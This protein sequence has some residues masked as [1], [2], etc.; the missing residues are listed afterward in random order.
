MTQPSTVASGERDADPATDRAAGSRRWWPGVAIAAGYLLVAVLLLHRQWADP[1]RHA[2]G[3]NPG[4]QALQEWYLAHGAHLLT[5]GHGGLFFTHLF[6]APDGVNLAANPSLILPALLLTPVTLLFGAPVAYLVLL[7]LALAGTATGWYLFLSRRFCRTRTA[8]ALG[9]GLCGFAPGMV[10]QTSG[11]ANLSTQILV[12]FLVW[13]V[14]R[15]ATDGRPVRDGVLLGLAIT[16]QALTGTEILLLTA[17]TLGIF[18]LAYAALA[19]RRARE[20]APRLLRGLG[21]AAAVSVPL[22][23]WPLREQFLGPMHFHGL[24]FDRT[25]YALRP[26]S[27]FQVPVQ[28][29][30]GA[31]KLSID[32]APGFAE[33]NAFYGTPLIMALCV[34]A[35]WLRRNAVVLAASVAAVV[36]ALL[37]LGP[38]IIL[39]DLDTGGVPGPWALFTHVPILNQSLPVRMALAVI[40]A[41]AVVLAAG[42]DRLGDLGR[43]RLLGVAGLVVALVPIV[44]TPLGRTVRPPVP[45]FITSGHWRQCTRPGHTLVPVPLPTPGDPDT[46]RWATAAGLGF[47]IPEG[48]F[49]GP[50]GRKGG[51]SA[52]LGTDRLT[53]P[54]GKL[55]DD[56]VVTGKPAA[57]GPAQRA[58]AAADLRY[59]RADCV[60]LARSAVHA[61]ALRTTLT[62]LLG[63][64]RPVDDVVIWDR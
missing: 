7:T 6:N 37:S 20:A 32:L 3:Y 39:K 42:A 49:L 64:G 58:R 13:L 45:H 22:L 61:G 53:R 55:L 9:G 29:P 10:A 46:M 31:E 14:V 11:H 62:R 28:S 51:D 12:P 18:S 38:R 50:T 23:A 40:P 4:D 15:L 43:Y 26:D 35:W 41:F 24:P 34:I 54:T 63:P 30:W 27:Y 48:F 25:Y 16:A 57:V 36:M 56:V 52:G 44:P 2:L 17:L 1:A 33:E 60:V 21:I 47:A 5:T 8:A 19:R 59:W